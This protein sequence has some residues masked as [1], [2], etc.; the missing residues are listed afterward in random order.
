MKFY[1][2]ILKKTFDTEE[3]CLTAEKE[4][5]EKKT[6][7]QKDAEDVKKLQDK[8]LAAYE[9]YRKAVEKFV[10]KH[11]SYKTTYEKSTLPILRGLLFDDF[12]KW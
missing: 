3:A 8:Y 7:R 2:E 12:L 6:A 5:E 4:A 1:S 10:E 11:G 9:E